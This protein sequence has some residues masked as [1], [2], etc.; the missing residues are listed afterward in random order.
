MRTWQVASQVASANFPE[1]I[2]RVFVV[3]APSFFPTVFNWAKKWCGFSRQ[4]PT[5]ISRN[6]HRVC[7]CDCRFDPGTVEKIHILGSPTEL[8]EFMPL[9]NI[10][11]E[12]GGGLDWTYGQPPALG[13]VERAKLGAD[14]DKLQGPICWDREESRLRYLGKEGGKRREG[15]R[16]TETGPTG[17]VGSVSATAD[18]E[19]VKSPSKTVQDAEAAAEAKAHKPASDNNKPLMASYIPTEG[20]PGVHSSSAMNGSTNGAPLVESPSSEAPPANEHHFANGTSPSND[21][22]HPPESGFIPGTHEPL[23][24][25]RVRARSL[26]P[27]GGQATAQGQED[28]DDET[29]QKAGE[30]QAS[31]IRNEAVA[32]GWIPGSGV[33]EQAFL[34]S[35]GGMTL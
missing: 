22:P 25:E 19:A 20:A 27:A 12:Y 24:E 18:G 17:G 4:L 14:G 10:P 16:A 32:K 26:P 15:A 33:T 34:R 21:P 7:D 28:A 29:Q 13:E 6:A 8:Q 11:K 35:V 23:T 1:T 3:G 9:D 2:D 31:R 5:L 30:E